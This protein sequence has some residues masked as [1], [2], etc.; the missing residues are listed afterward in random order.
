SPAKFTYVIAERED[1][2]P[3]PP[4]RTTL[5]FGVD[6]G[7]VTV[8]AGEG[9]HNVNDHESQRAHGILAITADTAATLGSNVG[10]YFAQSQLLIVLGPE[11][12]ATIAA[13]GFTRADVQR[14]VYEHARIPTRRRK[15]GGMWGH[16]DWPRWM[17]TADEDLPLPIVPGPDDVL[18]MVAGGAGK[19]RK[20]TR[21]NSSH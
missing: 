4:L 20:S 11:P 14:F 13:D 7:A 12:A 19:D 1:A 16:H 6:D 17:E 3:W 5:G 8:F 2:S 10:W 18:V 15:L 9:P 21:L